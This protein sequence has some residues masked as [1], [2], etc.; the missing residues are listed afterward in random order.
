MTTSSCW[1]NATVGRHFS[2]RALPLPLSSW[3]PMK[4]MTTVFF[5]FMDINFYKLG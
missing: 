2:Q 5:F 1:V 4:P 3:V